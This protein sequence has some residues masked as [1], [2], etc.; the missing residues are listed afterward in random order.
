LNHDL[1]PHVYVVASTGGAERRVGNEDLLFSE[2][3]PVWT[4]HGKRLLFFAGLAQAGSATQRRAF[5]QLY[6]VSL[7]KEEKNP[8]DRGVDDEEQAQA[9]EKLDRQRNAQ[10]RGEAPKPDVKIDFDGI[11][12]RAHQLTHLSD[13]I[14]TV[15]VS[16]DSRLYAVVAV[17]D[18]DGRPVATLYTIPEDGTQ[19]TT[20]TTSG[21]TANDE[22]GGGFGGPQINSLKFS[23][24]GRTIFFMEGEGLYAV[25]LGP[26]ADPSRGGAS[27]SAGAAPAPTSGRFERR[28][29][30][31]TARVEVDHRIEWKQVFN[32][33]WRV[34]KHR[35][36]DA[37]MHGVDWA[38]AKEVYEPLMD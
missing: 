17:A 15:A 31:F 25:D 3:H 16:P 11:T 6:S 5:V 19:T 8:T 20:I 36:Y 26:A 32:K 38:K 34:M 21:R 2:I 10:A 12:R 18:E 24:D 27:R 1:R 37:D 30:N 29:I 23:K 13:N 7:T 33:S 14:T 9:A 22:E 35:F 28:R 4:P